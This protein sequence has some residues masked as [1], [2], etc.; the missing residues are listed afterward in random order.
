MSRLLKKS[1]KSTCII[2][3]NKTLKKTTQKSRRVLLYKFLLPLLQTQRSFQ[4][5]N[6]LD[7]H[8]QLYAFQVFQSGRNKFYDQI[9]LSTLGFHNGPAFIFL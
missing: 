8:E 9:I 1:T 7:K 2:K 5:I 3:V 4:S 6:P